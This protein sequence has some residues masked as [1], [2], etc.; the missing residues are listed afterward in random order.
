MAKCNYLILANII[1]GEIFEQYMK[2]HLP[3][4]AQYGG[5]I[6]FRSIQNTPILGLENFDAIA[7]QEWASE[8]AFNAWWNSKEYKPW[9]Q[10]RDRA[11]KISIIQCRLND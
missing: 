8:E 6:I 9:A 1:E 11:A 7:I 4:I 2:G 3:T 5:N 10:I